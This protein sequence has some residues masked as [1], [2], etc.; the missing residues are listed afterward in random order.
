MGYRQMTITDLQEIFRR[1]H[2][3]H[4]ISSIKTATGTD[5]NTIRNY[6]RLFEIKGLWPHCDLPERQELVHTL[7]SVLPLKKRARGVRQLFEKHKEEIIELITRDK[8]PVKPKTAFFIIKEK[9][10]LPG[11]YETFKLWI[12]E[13]EYSIKKQ[14][15]PLR[16]E[17]APGEE[18]QIDYGKVGT[19]FDSVS[20]RNRSVYAFC[21][22]LSASRLPFV[23]FVFSQD[24][25][26]FVSSHIHMV[27]FY[28]G[29]TK[30]LTIDNLKS[31]VIKPDLYEPKLNRAYF[32]FAEYYGTFINPCRVG[33]ADD[34][35]KVE[36]SVPQA[37]ELFRRLKELHPSATLHELNTKARRLC[38]EEYGMKKHG[39]TG[40]EPLLL[41]EQEEKAALLELPKHRFLVPVWKYPIVQPD[42][43]FSFNGKYYA[44]PYSFRGTQVRVRKTNNT[45]QVFDTTHTLVRSYTITGKLFSSLPGD[46]PEDREA[47]MNGEYPQWILRKAGLYGPK[48]EELVATVLKP[49]AYINARR[50]RGILTVLQKYQSEPFF[51]DICG[52]ALQKRVHSPKQLTNMFESEKL[53]T[54]F[55]FISSTSPQGQAMVRDVSEYFN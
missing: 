2:A 45:L 15:A 53:Q 11:S 8:E 49:H 6:I 31:G 20:Q 19:Y 36:R 26:S 37:R 7:H 12:R 10:E 50:A 48:A 46:F 39:T 41:F 14:K 55:T 38:R 42:R 51:N 27:E 13:Q 30:F 29:I 33:K 24:Q 22:K 23:E 32:E 4:S 16:I 3:G 54:H 21:A 25:E 1:W 40:I 43:F 47:M 44:M 9:Y 18:T 35:G 17:L 28:G 5:R 52:K 34:K